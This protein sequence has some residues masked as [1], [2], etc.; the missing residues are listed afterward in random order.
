VCEDGRIGMPH[1]HG[2]TIFF[3]RMKKYDIEDIIL[4]VDLE[5]MLYKGPSAYFPG[6]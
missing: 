4:N 3:S 6:L 1:Q 5:K 2:Y